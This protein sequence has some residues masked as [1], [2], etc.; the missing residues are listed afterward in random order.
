[1]G[2]PARGATSATDVS[3]SSLRIPEGATMRTGA[4]ATD[5]PVPSRRLGFLLVAPALVLLVVGV[6]DLQSARRPVMRQLAAV[7]SS[8]LTRGWALRSA[9]FVPDGGA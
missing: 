3:S 6:G 8:E 1:A 4:E 7:G 2:T 5:R 9:S